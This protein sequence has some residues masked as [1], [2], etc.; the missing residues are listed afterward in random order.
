MYSESVV[1]SQPLGGRCRRSESQLIFL[2]IWLL[3]MPTLRIRSLWN[4]IKGH[5]SILVISIHHSQN[6]TLQT[7]VRYFRFVHLNSIS[8]H[9]NAFRYLPQNESSAG[10]SNPIHRIVLFPGYVQPCRGFLYPGQE[11][12]PHFFYQK[13]SRNSRGQLV[14]LA[15]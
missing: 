3:F 12:Q 1:T 6:P 2:F 7:Q 15:Q 9:H 4:G 11:R 5:N 10:T 13:P 14:G 8:I